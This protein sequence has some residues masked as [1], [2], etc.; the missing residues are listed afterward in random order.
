MGNGIRGALLSLLCALIIGGCDLLLSRTPDQHSIQS[1]VDYALSVEDRHVFTL[2]RTGMC[3][4][5]ENEAEGRHYQ[6]PLHIVY[7]DQFDL[8]RWRQSRDPRGFPMTTLDGS[9]TLQQLHENSIWKT[10]DKFF[11]ERNAARRGKELHTDVMIDSR[12]LQQRMDDYLNRV[13][14]RKNG[15]LQILV[16]IVVLLIPAGAIALSQHLDDLHKRDQFQ[17]ATRPRQYHSPLPPTAHEDV[18]TTSTSEQPPNADAAIITESESESESNDRHASA[19]RSSKRLQP[20]SASEFG[21]LWSDPGSWQNRA[22][23]GTALLLALGLGI[24][25]AM[26]P[27]AF[28]FMDDHWQVSWAKNPAIAAMFLIIY[29]GLYTAISV[30]LVKAAIRQQK[31]A[32]DTLLVDAEG[33][34]FL[35]KNREID[36]VL[37]S[38]LYQLQQYS[39]D[40]TL[41]SRSYSLPKGGRTTQ[42]FI[43][44]HQRN[45]NGQIERRELNFQ[46]ARFGHTW[47]R[48]RHALIGKYLQGI[49]LFRPDIRISP[50]VFSHFYI[51]KQTFLYDRGR[52]IRTEVAAWVLVVIV[53]FVIWLFTASSR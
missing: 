46:G 32:Y 17:Q 1:A 11:A 34:H 30:F 22:L 52:R 13:E 45:S 21:P 53:L 25:L 35:C 33:L 24:S 15:N 18:R 47:F 8:E 23:V 49:H 51:D 5:I 44:L 39:Y 27:I 42:Y 40:V 19:D 31:Q 36:S 43:E 37:F 9:F 12:D 7:Y 38:G 50:S 29:F 16:V 48:N 3:K 41:G 14:R 2:E 20:A 28:V 10:T 6:C 4:R 26:F